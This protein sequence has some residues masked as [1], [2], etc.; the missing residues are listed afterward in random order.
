MTRSTTPTL[1]SFFT[2]TSVISSVNGA[3]SGPEQD[4][5]ALGEC[6]RFY[7]K[8]GSFRPAGQGRFRPRIGKSAVNADR[9]W[10]HKIMVMI[11][12]LIISVIIFNFFNKISFFYIYNFLSFAFLTPSLIVNIGGEPVSFL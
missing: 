12:L 2:V 5:V 3:T 1:C 6:W 7:C 11:I 8:H 9:E 10:R 4:L